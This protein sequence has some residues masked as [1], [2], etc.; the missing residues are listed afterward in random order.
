MCGPNIEALE[1]LAILLGFAITT[2]N[3]AVERIAIL[4]NPEFSLAHPVPAR[5]QLAN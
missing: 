5:C 1:V 4:N 3:Q 2:T